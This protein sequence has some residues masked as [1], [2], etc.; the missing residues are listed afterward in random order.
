M[1]TH[2]YDDDCNVGAA[3]GIVAGSGNVKNI[4]SLTS[5]VSLMGIYEDYGPDYAG[6]DGNGWD[7]PA[8]SPANQAN[9]WRFA[10]VSKE[11]PGT[12]TK[13]TDSNGKQS[14]GVY[15]ACGKVWGMV[16]DSVGAAFT[17]TPYN[18]T[19]YPSSF[20]HTHQAINK[21]TSGDSDLGTIENCGVH[22]V[23]ELKQVSTFAQ[24]NFPS[25]AWVFE[26][27]AFPKLVENIN[28]FEIAK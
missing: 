28:R 10:G 16:Q 8:G 26:D 3:F 12:S 6:K 27:G 7:H 17:V 9:W 15:A 22:S 1:D 5:S 21:P 14:N 2:F 25:Y 18:E 20:G 13:L 4:I 11:V 23:T 19:G 24:Y